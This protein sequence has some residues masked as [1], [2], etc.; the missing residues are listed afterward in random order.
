MISVSTTLLNPTEK[1]KIQLSV[2]FNNNEYKNLVNVFENSKGTYIS[3]N[4]N[5][6]ITMKYTIPN[7]EWDRHDVVYINERNIYALNTGLKRFYKKLLR[8]NLFIY[9]T[10]GYAIQINSKGDDIETIPMTK[11]QVIQ[12]EP[13]IIHDKQG[14]PL[15]GVMLHINRSANQVDLSIDEYEA[16][17]NMFER[18]NIR[19]EGMMI[20]HLY[21][22]MRKH[23]M[24]MDMK[25]ENSPPQT[26]QIENRGGKSIFDR[27]KPDSEK[28]FV[29]SPTVTDKKEL[30]MNLPESIEGE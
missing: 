26:K 10:K 11:G 17:M 27:T 2:G 3:I 15:P 13:A 24:T 8:D 9:N 1:L 20:L 7:K 29:K 30:F 14:N 22:S 16:M 28:E 23:P 18:I 21:L 19:Q 5:I 4:P 6:N 12:I 25:M